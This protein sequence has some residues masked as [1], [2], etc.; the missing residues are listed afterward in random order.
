VTTWSGVGRH[1]TATFS[2][3]MNVRFRGVTSREGVVIGG[4]AGFGEFSPFWDYDAEESSAWLVAAVEAANREFPPAVRDRIAV[5][6]TVPAVEPVDAQAIVLSSHGCR[7]AK[8]K[9]A[10]PGQDLDADMARVSAVRSALGPDGKIRIDAN[11]CW[12]VEEAVVAIR[13]L[14][15]FGIEYVEQPCRSVEEL[16]RVRGLVGVPIA[17]DESI[18]RTGDPIRVK[19]LEAAD[20]AVLK[21]QPLGGVQA[22]MRVAELL[23]MPVVVSSALESSVGLAAGVALAAAL[24]DLPYACGL[25]TASMLSRDL[26]MDPFM[27]VDGFLAVR[28][29]TVDAEL[30][31]EAGPDAESRN[32]WATRIAECEGILQARGVS[33]SDRR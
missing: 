4:P 2:L 27:P 23:D 13:E 32:R 11:G 8:V 14:S 24:P 10:E 25:A 26:T 22:C 15:Q 16:R 31:A 7:T 1:T 30:L 20:I 33:Q 12:T 28:R 3:P 19:Q 18:R 6:C 5:N 17:A 9:V 29:P 21:V